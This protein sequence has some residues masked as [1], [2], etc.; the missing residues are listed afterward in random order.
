VASPDNF[1]A[2]VRNP[3]ARNPHAQMPGNPAYDNATIQ[4]LLAYFR[5][6][7]PQEKP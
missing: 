4:A 7:S 5:T 3:Q 1:F 6:F 2:Y